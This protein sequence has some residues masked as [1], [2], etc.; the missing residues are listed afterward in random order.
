MLLPL[1]MST[2]LGRCRAKLRGTQI[3]GAPVRFPRFPFGFLIRS[4]WPKAI[5]STSATPQ[6]YVQGF[7]KLFQALE[8]PQITI[9]MVDIVCPYFS[10][11][12]VASQVLTC[13]QS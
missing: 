9:G 11:V 2:T 12:G 7:L 10:T 3:E 8:M 1:A 13:R 6:F 5:I 4:P